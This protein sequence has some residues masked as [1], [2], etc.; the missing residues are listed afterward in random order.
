M[1][2]QRRFSLQFALTAGLGVTAALVASLGLYGM[3]IDGMAAGFRD[4]I[5]AAVEKQLRATADAALDLLAQRVREPLLDYDR[6][7]LARVARG[8]VSESFAET[9]RIYDN[10]G[11]AVADSLGTTVERADAAPQHLRGLEAGDGVRRWSEGDRLLA[12]QAVCIRGACIGAV[13]VAVD[14]SEVARERARLEQEMAV[15]KTAFFLRAA[16]LGLVALALVS[17]CAAL[18]GYLLGRRMQQSVTAAVEGLERIAEGA[19]SVKVTCGDASLRELAAAVEA[20]AEKLAAQAAVDP[21]IA[22]LLDGFMVAKPDGEIIVANA[23]LHELLRA[24]EPTLLGADA[25]GAFGLAPTPEP[26][27]FADELSAVRVVR[28]TDGE[29]VPVL[30]RA[31]VAGDAQGRKVVAMIRD[32]AAAIAAQAELEAARLRAEAAETAKSQFLSVMSH[33]LRTPLNGV[34]GGAAVL[35]GTP[36]DERQRTFVN[37]VQ[38]SGRALLRMVNSILTLARVDGAETAPLSAPV[39]LDAVAHEIASRVAD[40]AAAKGLALKIDIPPGAPVVLSDADRLI[41]IGTNLI[42]NA[43]KFTES[44]AVSLQ[45]GYVMKDG[46]AEIVL[47][48]TDTGPG[49]AEADRERIF[50]RFTQGDA[51]ERR[52][53]GG[54]GLGLAMARHLAEGLDGALEL[55]T[56]PGKGSTF[57]LRFSAP[58]DP[59]AGPAAPDLRGTNAVVVTATEADS[60]A[61]AGQL[62]HAGATPRIVA[63]AAGAAAALNDA[64]DGGAPV[65]VVIRTAELP[66]MAESGLDRLLRPE[67]GP[68][69]AASVVTGD[70]PGLENVPDYVQQTPR[71]PGTARLAAATD[72]ALTAAAAA[73]DLVRETGREAVAAS[74]E[75][76][77]EPARPARVAPATVLLAEENEV[78]RIVL[79]AFL[80]KAGYACHTAPNGV[81]AVRLYKEVHPRLALISADMP[82]M[83]GADA[84]RAIRRYEAETGLDEAPIIGLLSL[85]RDGER[86]ACMG[87]G[88]SD[89][90]RKPVKSPELAAKLERWTSLYRQQDQEGAA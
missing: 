27:R 18:V 90:L 65:H 30:T 63:D 9:V 83:N 54:V 69:A 67:S 88:M 20:L 66:G 84:A 64:G 87:A 13:S 74:D 10:H 2:L 28:A 78:N 36:L 33:E 48:V 52:E 32:G 6:E 85:K 51:S 89:H 70:E 44:G 72:A 17:L 12:G 79:S 19:R 31:R 5:E 23:A 3:R 77:A 11:R 15:A 46:A 8:V 42:E 14:G 37:V 81:E 73:R 4:D 35:A 49:I 41:Q 21:M 58:V 80:R 29:A 7:G 76:D 68:P 39:D 56:E 75:P 40:A 16:L 50:D 62:S 47:S 57:R 26:E 86:E 55:D 43:V 34:L 82:V 59:A 1:S 61:L 71:H 25:F 53:H 22:E 60:A 45:L 38:N 24:P